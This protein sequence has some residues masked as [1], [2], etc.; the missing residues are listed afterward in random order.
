MLP[1]P[2]T[3]VSIKP[4]VLLGMV[5]SQVG[6]GY[7][8]DRILPGCNQFGSGSG[9]GFNLGTRILYFL[10]LYVY[11]FYFLVIL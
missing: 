11:I 4:W 9:S 6:F 2:G 5:K 7:Y 10:I 3:L 1:T 8:N